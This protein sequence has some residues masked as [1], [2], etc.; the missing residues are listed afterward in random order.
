[1]TDNWSVGTNAS[2]LLPFIARS[3]AGLLRTRYRIYSGANT[4]AVLDGTVLL[5]STK[6]DDDRIFINYGQVGAN[7][8]R[9]LSPVHTVSGSFVVARLGTITTTDGETTD[10]VS[11]RGTLAAVT[12]ELT[13]SRWFSL[14][15]SLFHSPQ[16]ILFADSIG[17][18]VEV[19]LSGLKNPQDRSG[20]RLLASF[21]FGRWLLTTGG[22]VSFASTTTP[23]PWLSFTREYR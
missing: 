1:M 20:A 22:V 9:R 7:I 6:N 15:T 18:T 17:Q 13:P 16:L 21:H 10:V 2:A 5:S 8:S 4:A 19:Q 11:G 3:P 12:H 23:L 14:R